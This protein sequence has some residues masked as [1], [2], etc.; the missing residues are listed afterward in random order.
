MFHGKAELSAIALVNVRAYMVWTIWAVDG[1]LLRLPVNAK[2]WSAPFLFSIC[3]IDGKCENY[4]S[5][6]LPETEP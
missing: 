3:V 5:L 2:E 6:C 4:Q 1:F